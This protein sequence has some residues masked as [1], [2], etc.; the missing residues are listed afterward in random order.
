MP[1]TKRLINSALTSLMFDN[2]SENKVSCHL[3]IAQGSCN[4]FGLFGFA[5]AG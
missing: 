2:I 3:L 4:A 5:T 1:Q